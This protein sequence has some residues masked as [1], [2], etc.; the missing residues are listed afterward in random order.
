[1]GWLLILE[2]I[3]SG[4]KLET[5]RLWLGSRHKD[6]C[7][8]S[9]CSATLRRHNRE[10]TGIS[11]MVSLQNVA[12]SKLSLALAIHSHCCYCVHLSQVSLG[13]CVN[14]ICSLRLKNDKE[15]VEGKSSTS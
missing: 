15:Q 5:K 6:E 10:A 11:L 12:S 1:M 2:K 7:A 13:K 8:G 3:L 4:N 14:E 9:L